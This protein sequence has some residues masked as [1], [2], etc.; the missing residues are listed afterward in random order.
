MKK[1]RRK[2]FFKDI[3]KKVT[4]EED[5][6]ING[7]HAVRKQIR[8]LVGLMVRHQEV[9]EEREEE[10]EGRLEKENAAGGDIETE[11]QARRMAALESVMNATLAHVAYFSERYQEAY[12]VAKYIEHV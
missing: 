3:D 11:R 9:A 10:R 8:S 4:E 2:D 12:T 7:K 6:L 5:Q 1:R